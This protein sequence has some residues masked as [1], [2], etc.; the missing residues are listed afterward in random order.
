MGSTTALRREIEWRVLPH[1]TAR[2]FVID[3]RGQP[4]MQVFRR[5]DGD[6]VR[7]ASLQWDKYGRPRFVVH[8]GTCAAAGLVVGERHFA[9]GDVLP[10]WLPECGT[11]QPRRGRTSRAWF[12]QD[13]PFF[14]RLVSGTSLRTVTA[15]VDDLLVLFQEVDAYWTSGAVGPHLRL[16]KR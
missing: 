15:V 14:A 10:T 7:I 16:W 4:R 13:V 3:W 2:G 6:V 1:L 12:R 5:P 8:F 11:L 9:A